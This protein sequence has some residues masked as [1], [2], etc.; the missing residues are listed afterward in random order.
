MNKEAHWLKRFFLPRD[1]GTL[2][3]H[4]L[5]KK[6]HMLG[7]IL[8]GI[9]IA[10]FAL[11]SIIHEAG[12][13]IKSGKE[14]YWWNDEFAY[15]QNFTVKNQEAFSDISRGQTIEITFDHQQLVKDKKAN[16]SGSD[17]RAVYFD[18][19][20]YINLPLSLRNNWNKNDTT[21]AFVSTVNIG[22]GKSDNAFY[23]YYGNSIADSNLTSQTDNPA[24]AKYKIE[25]NEED[26][27]PFLA[28]V[29]RRWNLIDINKTVSLTM[30][31][32]RRLNNPIATYHILGTAISGVME[33]TDGSNFD[34]EISLNKLPAGKYQVQIDIND[35]NKLLRSQKV[36]FFLSSPLYIAWTLDWEGYDAT[37]AYLDALTNISKTYKI[38]MTHFWN[39]RI[40]VTTEVSTE[41][42]KFLTNWVKE[43][44]EAGDGIGLH[45]HMF[46]DLV[47]S[48]GIE[49][50]H[51]PNWGDDGNGYGVPTS[52][53][54]AS[55]LGKILQKSVSLMTEN[56]LPQ[57]FVYRAGG[58]FANLDTLAA[59]EENGF[60]AD[61]SGRTS[62]SFG[63]NNM[64]GDWNLKP[65][66]EP[67]LPSKTNQNENSLSN[68]FNLLEIPNNGA[69]S[70][71]FSADDMIKRFAANYQGGV[72]E[73]KKQIT[74]LTHPHW[75][76]KEEQAKVKTLFD[77]LAAF[78][79]SDDSGPIIYT[80]TPDIYQIWMKD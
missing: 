62:Y 79:Y 17:I 28:Q 53:Y 71:W 18:G 63:R 22:G 10:V 58:W 56:G 13:L 34:S 26:Q 27:Y 48:A 49:P 2:K 69:D 1:D 40:Y 57:P 36:G 66:T 75:F 73:H 46:Y 20:S 77:H 54:S 32:S 64:K 80:T 37:N 29:S 8:V 52:S 60:L 9:V 65:E 38:P 61:S 12:V 19:K 35:E 30:E 50:K 55:D 25:W 5:L 42:Q 67:Y 78:N 51:D 21:L 31:S 43:H 47:Q 6:R 11:P 59:L 33:N 24:L 45:T 76:K 41:R 15:R 14:V 39:S 4:R 7:G 3:R 16:L 72:L 70:Y 74:Y 44:L 23:L 68:A